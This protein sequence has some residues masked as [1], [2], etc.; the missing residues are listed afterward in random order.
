MRLLET[1]CETAGRRR[2]FDTVP[3]S[4]D[5]HLH[6]SKAGS[7][8]GDMPHANVDRLVVSFACASLSES[9]LRLLDDDTLDLVLGHMKRGPNLAAVAAASST[10][11][12]LRKLLL[13]DLTIARRRAH[14]DILAKVRGDS[15]LEP[16]LLGQTAAAECEEAVMELSN[17]NL[18]SKDVNVL[19]SMLRQPRAFPQL[20]ELDLSRN[21]LCDV[22]LSAI[23]RSIQ[24][25]PPA[26]RLLQALFLGS[27]PKIGDDGAAALALAIRKRWA[28]PKL[29]C[30]GLENTS[31]GSVGRAA[32]G[33]ALRGG[34]LP[35]L[36]TL[37]V[38]A[39]ADGDRFGGF[40]SLG[41]SPPAA[42]SGADERSCTPD[43]LAALCRARGVQTPGLS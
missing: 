38:F 34:A 36:E 41:P 6:P 25:P 4:D 12:Q 13:P 5:T 15:W 2:L 27:N 30:L 39:C 23:A 31:I 14:D 24:Q 42:P 26:L 16:I 9:Q 20:I 22:A 10:C 1:L 40:P 3:R 37:Y 8:Q 33:N 11:H 35:R 29:T 19:V 28:L 21:Q 18:N 43:D 17:R 32:I 7:R